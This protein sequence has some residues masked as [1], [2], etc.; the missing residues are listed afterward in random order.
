MALPAIA[1]AVI[2]L[3][4]EIIRRAIP[5]PEK[6][7]QAIA[8][9][10]TML[11]QGQLT[12]IRTLADVVIAEAQ[13]ESWLQRNWRPILMLTCITIVAFNFLVVPIMSWAVVASGLAIIP[14][15]MIPM[16]AELWSLMTLGVG[17]YVAGRTV[18]KTVKTWKDN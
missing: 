1:A 5:D 12:E 15:P 14:P 2:P 8:K 9:V 11:I 13:G 17:G 4:S 6:A 10:N 7:D 3:I 18:E 16:P